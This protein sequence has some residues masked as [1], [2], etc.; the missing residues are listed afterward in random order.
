M[1][2]LKNVTQPD[3]QPN[4]FANGCVVTLRFSLFLIGVFLESQSH[5][6]AASMFKASAS[7]A[8]PSWT[9]GGVDVPGLGEGLR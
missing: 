4:S 1:Y 3:A 2:R 6:S 7:A 9:S 8:V 5:F